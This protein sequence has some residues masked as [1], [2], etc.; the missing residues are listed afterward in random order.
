MRSISSSSR[1]MS[2][3]RSFSNDVKRSSS[4][5]S[6]NRTEEPRQYA[7]S[8]TESS[9]ELRTRR[10]QSDS[11]GSSSRSRSYSKPRRRY[12]RDISE[13][14]SRSR[15]IQRSRI[16]SRSPVRSRRKRVSRSV[17]SYSHSSSYSSR[18]RSRPRRQLSKSRTRRGRDH[19]K[20]RS[21]SVDS[22]SNYRRRSS[23]STSYSPPRRRGRDQR[24]VD[25]R[26]NRRVARAPLKP[27]RSR[28]DAVD[29][30]RTRMRQ[31]VTRGREAPIRPLRP[32]ARRVGQK[33][34]QELQKVASVDRKVHS[35]FLLRIYAFMDEA[36]GKPCDPD[37]DHESLQRRIE[38]SDSI[39]KLELYIWADN[40]LRDLVNLVKD[41]CEASRHKEGTWTFHRNNAA[42]DT[43]GAIHSY[44]L[45]RSTDTITLRSVGFRVG[46]SL[47]LSFSGVAP[48][49]EEN[50]QMIV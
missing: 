13:S 36:A 33:T 9:P 31:L 46:D 19:R 35:P 29:R 37:E 49:P 10:R 22:R 40:T 5:Y 17:S 43:L 15:S 41:L 48:P 23:T 28:L 14:R 12:G 4:H 44:K 32:Y 11:R 18:S 7:R 21:I 26:D 6:K 27:Y 16:R 50:T 47:L 2:V 38:S 42:R 24:A 20:S 25:S 1:S 34:R 45:H 30:D 8:S 3:S 39:E